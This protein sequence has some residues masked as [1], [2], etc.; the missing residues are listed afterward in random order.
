MKLW[1][2]VLLCFASYTFGYWVGTW[3]TK[4]RLKKEFAKFKKTYFKRSKQ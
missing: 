3:S 2:F 4:D 1:I